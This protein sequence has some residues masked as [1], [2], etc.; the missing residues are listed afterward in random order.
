MVL[1][2]VINVSLGYCSYEP[3]GEPPRKIE[4]HIPPPSNA[5]DAGTAPADG[6]LAP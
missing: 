3:P 5:R 2:G 1:I 6:P 4:V